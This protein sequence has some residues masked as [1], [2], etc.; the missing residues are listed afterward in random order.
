MRTKQKGMQCTQ[1]RLISGHNPSLVTNR[2]ECSRAG[3]FTVA[4]RNFF[5]IDLFPTVLARVLLL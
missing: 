5:L 1:G 4:V 3:R 2:K